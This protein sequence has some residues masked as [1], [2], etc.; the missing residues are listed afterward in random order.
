MSRQTRPKTRGVGD[1]FGVMQ[2]GSWIAPLLSIVGLVVVLLVSLSLLGVDLRIGGGGN[3]VVP[4]NGGTVNRTPAPSNVVLPEPEAAFP[5]SIVYAKAGNIW[6]QTGDDVRELTDTGRD[7]MPSWSPDGKTIYFIRTTIEMGVWPSQGQD[8]RYEMTVPNLMAVAADG[9]A[10]PER[11]R[12][13]K[14]KKNGKTWFYWMRQPVLSPNGKTFALVSDGPDPTKSNVV[15]QFWDM[16]TKK[17]TVPDVTE[18]PPLGHQDPAWRP[19]GKMLFYVRNGRE[20]AKGAPIIYR[21]DV[22][23]K[24]SSAVTGPGYLEPSFSPDGRYIAATRINAFGSDVVILDAVRGRELL[25]LTTDGASWAPTWSPKGDAIA[26]FHIDGQ[27]VD[28]KMAV[29]DGKAPNWTVAETTALTTVSGL[30][31]S[32]RPDWFIPADELPATPPPSVP[33]SASPSPSAS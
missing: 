3:P 28:L 4:G 32:S 26:F 5:G 25:R 17:T 22:A 6:I 8:R 27:I 11:L 15:L 19:D 2:R 33:A 30:D 9:S 31:G 16:N 20:G 10:T 21:W 29:L 1:P 7:S 18:I 13:G 12:S 14:F 24:T 23:K